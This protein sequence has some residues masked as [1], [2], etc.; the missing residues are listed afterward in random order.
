MSSVLYIRYDYGVDGDYYWIVMKKYT[1]SLK[2]WRKRQKAPLS[3]N[4]SLYMNIFM[5]VLNI[6]QFLGENRIQLKLIYPL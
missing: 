3:Q 4:L 6:M 1:T 5:S 2:E